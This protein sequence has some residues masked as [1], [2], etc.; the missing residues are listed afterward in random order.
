M[1]QQAQQKIESFLNYEFL[2]NFIYEYLLALLIFLVGIFI[3]NFIIKGVII[4]R[5]RKWIQKSQ[6]G[7]NNRLIKIFQKSIIPLLYLGVVYIS[8]SNL[9]LH[10]IL[11]QA[12]D[13]VGLIIATFIG[14]RFIGNVI[15]YLLATYW[16]KG[17]DDEAR[18]QSIAI[19]SPALRIITWTIGI[20]FLLGNL[21]FDISA[22]I[23]SLGIGG[24][25]IALAAQGV[26]QELFSYFSILLDRPVQ[27]GDFIIVGDLIGTVEQIGI[28][29][30]RLRSLSGEELILSNSDLTS[31]RIHNYK[32]M[33]ERRIVFSIGVTYE[34]TLEQLQA[35]PKSIQTI[36]E[37]TENTRFDRCHFSSYGD[38]SLNFETVYYMETPDY[39]AYMDAQ[40]KINFAIKECF[41]A[42]NIEMAYPTEVHYVNQG[43]KAEDQ[44]TT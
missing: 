2:N 12:I 35:I 11:K 28:K 39:T 14:I 10:P 30:T 33:E 25:A 5:L 21:G 41:E 36:V 4:K 43:G 29:T 1:D 22:L 27:I 24:I 19:L 7:V 38:F 32:R 42:E 9:E 44:V 23:A 34:T 13:V 20:I 40:Q 17:E 31:S 26:F 8:I 15:E 6:I 16:L 18:E 3:I 37:Q